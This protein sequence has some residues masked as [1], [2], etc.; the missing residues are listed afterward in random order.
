[1]F[2]GSFNSGNGFNQ[3]QPPQPQQQPQGGPGTP[4]GSTPANNQPVSSGFGMSS[5]LAPT[6]ST[7]ANPSGMS[8]STNSNHGSVQMNTNN[9]HNNNQ[10][11]FGFGV[12]STTVVGSGFASSSPFARPSGPT[13]HASPFSGGGMGTGSGFGMSDSLALGGNA[14][15]SNVSAGAPSPFGTSSTLASGNKYSFSTYIG[16]GIWSFK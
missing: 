2:G 5:T 14:I 1:M 13:D 16:I 11:G 3:Q 15:T 7:P 12:S 10:S 6:P 4:F 9:D 8:M